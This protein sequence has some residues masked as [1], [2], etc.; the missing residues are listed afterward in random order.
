MAS[1]LSGKHVLVLGLGLHGGAVG[2]IL[3]LVK[4]GAVI[5]VSDT[6]TKEQLAPS[7]EKLKDIP[8]ITYLFGSQDNLDLDKIDIIIR[9]PAVPRN[10]IILQRAKEK[11]IPIEM[12]SSL[13]FEYSESKNII[14]ITGSKGKPTASSAISAVMNAINADTMTVGVDGVSP[15]GALTPLQPSL[16]EL[17]PAGTP[18]ADMPI[19]FELSSWRLEALQEKK[20]SP[21][22]AVVTSIYNDHL[23][24]YSSY[25][26]YIDTKKQIIQDQTENDI[27]ILNT[28]DEIIRG[29]KMSVKGQLYLY[30]LQPLQKGELG[31]W[32][33]KDTIFVR[34]KADFLQLSICSVKDIPHTS[35]HE[36]RNKL[37]A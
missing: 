35:E 13:F 1:S 33:E 8:N 5:S 3:W 14:G 27:A 28:D 26:E 32:V 23:N 36:L 7:I 9:G 12:D 18:F 21:H 31:V 29:W 15:L 4:Q 10:S 30:S 20:I 22:I 37:P 2:T 11:N 34:T 16:E 25:E 6:K 19:V 17:R 24:T